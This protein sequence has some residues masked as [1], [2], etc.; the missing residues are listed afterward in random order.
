MSGDTDWQIDPTGLAKVAAGAKA[1]AVTNPANPTGSVLSAASRAALVETAKR[2]DAWLMVDEIYRGGE[3]DGAV[4]IAP[5][6]GS[7]TR[8]ATK[9]SAAPL[10]SG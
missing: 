3:I 1:I 2:N 5:V 9:N 4:T 10:N 7:S 6:S 8:V